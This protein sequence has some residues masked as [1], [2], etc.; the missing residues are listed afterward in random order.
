[1]LVTCVET[2]LQ[3]VLAAVASV[4]PDL[5][6]TSQQRVPY[7]DVVKA[8]SLDALVDEMR[9]R[10]ARAWLR[11]GGPTYWKSRLEKMGARE[12]PANLGP[13]LEQIWAIRH[14]VVHA[15]GIANTAFVKRHPGWV[16]AAGHRV[17]INSNAL[18]RFVDTITVFMKATETFFVARY[19]S[20]A[21]AVPRNAKT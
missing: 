19:P 18:G 6:S 11:K 5:M 13:R 15:A 2:Y 3:D 4:D 20:M 14:L 10:W 12:Y 16:D 21:A 17:R 1:M 9:A 8:T 7:A